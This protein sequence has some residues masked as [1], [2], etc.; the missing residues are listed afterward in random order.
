M[1]LNKKSIK[2]WGIVGIIILWGVFFWINQTQTTTSDISNNTKT[3]PG[4]QTGEAPWIPEIS[5]LSERWIMLGLP[6]LRTEGTTFHIHIHLDIFINGYPV[7][8]PTYI[9]VNQK[10]GQISDIHTHDT[11]GIIHIESPKVQA[12]TLGQF[13]GI[14]GV[15]FTSQNIGGYKNQSDKILKVF[16]NGKLY[17][18]DSSQLELKSHQEIAITYGT[19]K[20]L[21]QPIPASYTFPAGY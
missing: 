10:A 19:D 12:L 1:S 2:A 11:T 14:W 6:L 15:D 3:L 13:F 9:G 18:G 16:V 4:I 20:E 8:V 7:W 5:N 17:D 21:P